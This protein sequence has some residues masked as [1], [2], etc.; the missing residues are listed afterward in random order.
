MKRTACSIQKNATKI[1]NS[2][3]GITSGIQRVLTDALSA[4]TDAKGDAQAD[5]VDGQQTGAVA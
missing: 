4:L 5:A 2:C 1:E 3:T